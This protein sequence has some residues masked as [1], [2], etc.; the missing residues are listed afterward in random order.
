MAAPSSA[1]NRFDLSISFGEFNLLS[2]Q[3]KFIGLKVLPPVSVEQEA[4]SFEL[5]QQRSDRLVHTEFLQ[6]QGADLIL[7]FDSRRVQNPV[8]LKEYTR[9]H[10]SA[11]ART[12]P[13]WPLCRK[14]AGKP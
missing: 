11:R 2:N 8:P 4:A 3:K 5:A 14:N 10:S 13:T 1:I 9:L 12:L 7:A 6:C